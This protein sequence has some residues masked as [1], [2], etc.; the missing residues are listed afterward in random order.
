M[1]KNGGKNGKEQQR[2]GQM[3]AK[4]GAMNDKEW[5]RTAKNGKYWQRMAKNSIWPEIIIRQIY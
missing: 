5:Q 4:N 3:G 2:T 1:A